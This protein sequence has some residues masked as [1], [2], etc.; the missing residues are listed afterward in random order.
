MASEDQTLELE[1]LA[2][3]MGEDMWS[4]T[5]RAGSHAFYVSPQADADIERVGCIVLLA[6]LPEAYPAVA[7]SFSV[8]SLAD[9]LW[10]SRF[11]HRAGCPDLWLPTADQLE[12]LSA[13]ASSCAQQHAESEPLLWDVVE[14]VREWLATHTLAAAP[15]PPVKDA[16]VSDLKAQLDG[17]ELSEDDLELDEEDMDEEM[18]DA[19]R[20]VLVLPRDKPLERKLDMAAAMKT[21]SNAQRA[22]LKEVWL[23]LSHAQR[24]QMV[25]SD[26]EDDSD[27]SESEAAE[28]AA[29]AA[30]AASAAPRG[31]G[32]KA[33][34]QKQAPLPPAAQ[35]S[36]P[37]G[38][39]LTAVNCKPADYKRLDG[40]EGNCDLCDV[41]FYYTQGGYHCDSCR[42]WDC[43]VAC[44]SRPAAGGGKGK[45]SKGRKK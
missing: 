20:E 43:C 19:V 21:N 41:D 35:R 33:K 30:A 5:E 11:F 34:Q 45:S 8:A 39:C 37:R 25:A 42:N 27:D 4:D 10:Q 9:P 26:D 3:I 7:P 29:A 44:G 38:H 2:A 31:G 40:N 16:E 24:K 36:C 6:E 28:A 32:K 15:P 12:Q 1:A 22:A 17:A 18:I 14:A 23:A 13:V